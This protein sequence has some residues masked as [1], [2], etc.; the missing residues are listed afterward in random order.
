[1]IPSAALSPAPKAP[2]AAASTAALAA[3][4]A[5]APEPISSAAPSRGV[6]PS[7]AVQEQLAQP[8][9]ASHHSLLG[10]PATAPLHR[11]E[12]VEIPHLSPLQ[13]LESSRP[14]W[15]LR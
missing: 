15:V 4:S 7:A 11:W 8:A 14:L 1:M 9:I 6:V 13:S 12:A 5:V 3:P 10:A 2:P